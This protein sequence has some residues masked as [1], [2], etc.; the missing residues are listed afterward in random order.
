MGSYEDGYEMDSYGYKKEE[1][2]SLGI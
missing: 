2:K 1:K